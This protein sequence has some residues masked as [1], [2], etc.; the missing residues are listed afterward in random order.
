MGTGTI[1]VQLQSRL[2]LLTATT[3]YHVESGGCSICTVRC[4][5][6]IIVHSS[7]EYGSEVRKFSFDPITDTSTAEGFCM[8]GIGH[9]IESNGIS[10]GA[11]YV[12]HSGVAVDST[13]CVHTCLRMSSHYFVQNSSP[14]GQFLQQSCM[15]LSGSITLCILA[16]GILRYT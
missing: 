13:D 1:M 3:M 5:L 14:T 8:E 12:A 2:S 11:V 10:P 4:M 16:S 15:L 6:D 9:R 7:G